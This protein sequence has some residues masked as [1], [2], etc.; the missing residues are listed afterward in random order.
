[1]P[2][3]LVESVKR[4]TGEKVQGN[5]FFFS[6]SCHQDSFAGKRQEPNLTQLT[7][8]CWKGME[9]FT[10]PDYGEDGGAPEP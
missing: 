9:Y 8:I 2:N 7:G 6:D 5:Y 10:Q 4:V 1:M 3:H